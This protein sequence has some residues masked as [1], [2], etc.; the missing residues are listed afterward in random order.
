MLVNGVAAGISFKYVPDVFVA[1]HVGDAEGKSR[2][3][4]WK[5]GVAITLPG[6]G[7][8]TYAS[9]IFVLNDDVYVAGY[10]HIVTFGVARWWKNGTEMPVSTRRCAFLIGGR[11]SGCRERCIYSRT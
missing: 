7:Q 10:R 11:N 9:E 3:T 8:H 6:P 2:A 5:N 1:G 4:L